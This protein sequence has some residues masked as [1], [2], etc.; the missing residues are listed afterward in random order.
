M[1]FHLFEY[2]TEYSN[3]IIVETLVFV[4]TIVEMIWSSPDFEAMRFISISEH[5]LGPPT[6]QFRFVATFNWQMAHM[7][8]AFKAT[9]VVKSDLS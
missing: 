2:S 8:R 4:L 5:L 6:E 3:S 7:R 9:I 1:F